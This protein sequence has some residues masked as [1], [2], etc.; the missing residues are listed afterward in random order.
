MCNEKLKNTGLHGPE[1]LSTS[2][3]FSN[4]LE[5]GALTGSLIIS[6]LPVMCIILL[7]CSLFPPSFLAIILPFLLGTLGYFQSRLDLWP[8]DLV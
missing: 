3:H 7:C 2:M 5:V 6:R 4:Y 8:G 1:M